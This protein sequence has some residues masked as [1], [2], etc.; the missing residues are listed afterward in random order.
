MCA[1]GLGSSFLTIIF[2]LPLLVHLFDVQ[3]WAFELQ[4]VLPNLCTQSNHLL[5]IKA[6]SFFDHPNIV[7]LYDIIELPSK[8]FGEVLSI[9]PFIPS[10]FLTLKYRLGE[11]MAFFENSTWY[12]EEYSSGVILFIYLVLS[13]KF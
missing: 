10:P 6:L 2:Q 11:R 5:Q 13:F 1:A 3:R 4:Q 7:K 12:L 9:H 8:E